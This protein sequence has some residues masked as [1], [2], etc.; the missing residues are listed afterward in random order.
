M[1]DV[2]NIRVVSGNLF[3]MQ[4][5]FVNYATTES[6]YVEIYGVTLV[7]ITKG[8]TLKKEKS[9]FYYK[10]IIHIIN[11]VIITLANKNDKTIDYHTYMYC[12]T[13]NF[14]LNLK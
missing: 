7:G 10:L 14:I 8:V 2:Q 4:C 11:T 1:F 12:G 13:H 3:C 5:Y 9:L 6:C